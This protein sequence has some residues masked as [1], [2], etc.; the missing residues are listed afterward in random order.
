MV[1]CGCLVL[2][3]SAAMNTKRLFFL[4]HEIQ[5]LQNAEAFIPKPLEP[6]A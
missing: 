2:E 6:K 3:P 5:V 4:N 1:V